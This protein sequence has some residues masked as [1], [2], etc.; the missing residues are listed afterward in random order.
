MSVQVRETTIDIVGIAPGT[1]QI[2]AERNNLT[3]IK[4]PSGPIEGS[5]QD[6]VV[7]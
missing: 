1:A 7:T 4:I 3:I 6:V 5:P 2:I